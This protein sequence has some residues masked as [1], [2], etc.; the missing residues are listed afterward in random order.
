MTMKSKTRT[1]FEIAQNDLKFAE[2]I[3]K[4]KNRP[5]YAVHFCHQ[6]IEKLLKAIITETTEELPPRTHNFQILF[7]KTNLKM[8]EGLQKFLYS[9]SPHYLATKYPEDITRLYKSYNP[10][11]GNKTLKQTKELFRWLEQRLK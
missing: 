6:A 4:N 3:L 5:C 7:Q 8:P 2:S 11:Y 1:W 9:L 10:A